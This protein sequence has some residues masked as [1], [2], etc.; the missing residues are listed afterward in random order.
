MYI[1]CWVF[2]TCAISAIS[3]PEH[4]SLLTWHFSLLSWDLI[5]VLCSF[6]S[7]F[8]ASFEQRFALVDRPAWANKLMKTVPNVSRKRQNFFFFGDGLF[9]GISIFKTAYSRTF[10][11]FLGLIPDQKMHFFT[12]FFSFF[13]TP[14][15]VCFAQKKTCKKMAL[16]HQLILGY[17]E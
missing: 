9:R 10:F 17:L 12:C 11:P 16:F 3:T 7:E 14:R 2:F 1:L 8:S 13:L 6:A 5:A 4:R 15:E